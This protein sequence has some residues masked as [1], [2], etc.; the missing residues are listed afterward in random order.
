MQCSGGREKSSSVCCPVGKVPATGDG[1]EVI[2]WAASPFQEWVHVK[3]DD[4][5][6]NKAQGSSCDPD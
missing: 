3:V 4:V 5:H 2:D 6:V 1:W